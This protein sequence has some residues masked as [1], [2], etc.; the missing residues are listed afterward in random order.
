MESEAKAWIE[1]ILNERL[2]ATVSLQQALCSG[3]VLC[4]VVRRLES[5]CPAPSSSTQKFRQMSNISNYLTAATAL[6][7]PSHD[8]SN[9]VD[10]FEDKDFKDNASFFQSV[11]VGERTRDE[12]CRRHVWLQTFALLVGDYFRLIVLWKSQ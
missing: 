7:V 9:T 5:D 1:A 3:V 6:G 2:P 10:L 4:N 8:M 11:F 12:R